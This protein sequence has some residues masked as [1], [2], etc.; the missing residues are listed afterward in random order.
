[1]PIALVTP[2]SESYEKISKCPRRRKGNARHGK[3]GASP[4]AAE[5]SREVRYNVHFVNQAGHVY[6]AIE[7]AHHSDE[8][9]I[10]ETYRIDVPS[11]GVGFDIWQDGRLVLRHRREGQAASNGAASSGLSTFDAD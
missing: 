5:I 2:V 9:A 4:T 8:A 3:R 6:D 10:D 1:M 7:I 11:I